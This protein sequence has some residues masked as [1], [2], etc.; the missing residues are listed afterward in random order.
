MPKFLPAFILCYLRM[1]DFSPPTPP[2]FYFFYLFIPTGKKQDRDYG[3]AGAG[4]VPLLKGKTE[5]PDVKIITWPLSGHN[6][7]V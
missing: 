1:N 3:V 2:L 6:R 4:G 5:I 7:T